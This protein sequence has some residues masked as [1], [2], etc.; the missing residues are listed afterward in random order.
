MNVLLLIFTLKPR[1]KFR[2]YV[3]KLKT[4]TFET[5]ICLIQQL[6][7][8][9]V[10]PAS[11]GRGNC[12]FIAEALFR[13]NTS[14]FLG[15]SFR[16]PPPPI[17]PFARFAYNYM[18]KV[19]SCDSRVFPGPCGASVPHSHGYPTVILLQG[20]IYRS[21]PLG[22]C[23]CFFGLILSGLTTDFA[24]ILIGWYSLEEKR[25]SP[26]IIEKISLISY[27]IYFFDII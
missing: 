11:G 6:R 4:R 10:R 15:F 16:F 20:I 22:S 25:R 9:L 1:H 5:I 21:E 23:V 24:E 19:C 14:D 8:I 26:R 3:E 27:F 2:L 18:N 13:V 12:F 17:L 7:V